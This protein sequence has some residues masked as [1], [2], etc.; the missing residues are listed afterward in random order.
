MAAK[1]RLSGR[2]IVSI[3]AVLLLPA[4]CI[5]QS[6]STYGDTGTDT[7]P[8]RSS[9]FGYELIRNQLEEMQDSITQLQQTAESRSA[10]A[11]LEANIATILRRLETIENGLNAMPQSPAISMPARPIYDQAPLTP[12]YSARPSRG[13]TIDIDRMKAEADDMFEEQRSRARARAMAHQQREQSVF[14]RVYDSCDDVPSS[15]TWKIRQGTQIA[16]VHCIKF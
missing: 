10:C 2:C 15:G 13:R 4:S 7:V 11:G 14:D 6:S 8:Q 16:N 12:A 1:G 9:G 3:A 5:A